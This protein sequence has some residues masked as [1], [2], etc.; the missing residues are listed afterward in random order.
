MS[1]NSQFSCLLCV[2]VAG[3]TK[4]LDRLGKAEA[5]RA[6]ER[7]LN[8]TRRAV[9]SHNGRVLKGA[10]DK[11]FAAFG[12]VDQAVQAACEMQQRVVQLPPVSGL[13]LAV[14]IGIQLDEEMAHVEEASANAARMAERLAGLAAGGQI[15]TTGATI[16]LL[17]PALRQATR[18]TELPTANAEG[19]AVDA[20]EVM[21]QVASDI[22][23]RPATPVARPLPLAR[24]LLWHA[25]RE[26]AFDTARGSLVLGRDA[27]CDIVI[28]DRR[29]SRQHAK[30]ELRH[31]KF[32]LTDQ[33]T[34]GTFVKF[35]GEPELVL[36]HANIVL[37]GKG[38]ISFG[39]GY[40]DGIRE[41]VAFEVAL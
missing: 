9:D 27:S 4:L 24:L 31:D 2:D 13:K 6:I 28:G 25:S 33:S 40:S 38:R 21:W 20:F 18:E 34:N 26:V 16:S 10:A 15:I 23:V 11:V 3:S 41:S 36:K 14:R 17:A 37:R 7:C 32:V 29:A 19:G 8:R 39:Q 22:A 35:D 12:S 1:A 5:M 30:I